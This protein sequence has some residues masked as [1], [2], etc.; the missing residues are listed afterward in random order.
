[1]HILNDF[2]LHRNLGPQ[3]SDLGI[4]KTTRY[5]QSDVPLDGGF[6]S[7]R[8]VCP[9]LMAV[10]KR[11]TVHVSGTRSWSGRRWFGRKLGRV[12]RII[13]TTTASWLVRIIAIVMRKDELLIRSATR[14][15]RRNLSKG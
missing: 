13:Y 7:P 12:G 8:A 5:S 15:R 3:L 14:K 1:M 4:G 6:S 10:R 2:I 11:E 9:R